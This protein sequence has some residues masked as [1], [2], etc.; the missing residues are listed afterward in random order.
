M[1]LC[2]TCKYKTCHATGIG[3]EF[4]HFGFWDVEPPIEVTSC[5]HYAE[6]KLPT[7]EEL[8]ERAQKQKPI[9]EPTE[10]GKAYLKKVNAVDQGSSD[11]SFGTLLNQI[12]GKK[13]RQKEVIPYPLTPEECRTLFYTGYDNLLAKVGKKRIVENQMKI[14]EVVK[15]FSGDPTCL[16]DLH[17]GIYLFGTVGVGKTVLMEAA[18][19][20][21]HTIEDRMEQAGMKVP[22]RGFRIFP[23]EGIV[24]EIEATKDLGKLQR[25]Y[26]G[27]VCLD[28]IGVEDPYNHYG[29][30]IDLVANI[31][32][33]RYKNYYATGQITH[34]TSNLESEKWGARYGERIDSRCSEMFNRVSL[35][36]EDKRKTTQFKINV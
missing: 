8:T 16:L 6:K 25:Y 13:V 18:N 19:L 1:N 7:M 26:K 2:S 20:F 33:E 31:L 22:N 14:D 4:C 17:K 36:G 5:D 32:S 12:Q 21:C 23:V 35:I 29:K 27:E 10:A 24:S 11:L 3:V 9:Q 34:A 28:D 15:Y 30:P